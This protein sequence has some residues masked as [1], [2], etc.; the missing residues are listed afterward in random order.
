MCG[1][2]GIYNYK[3][4]SL[5]ESYVNSCLDTMKHRGP[6]AQKTWTNN[7]NY[8][9]GFTR[10]AIRDLSKNGN[11]PMLSHD[12]NYCISFNGEIYNTDTLKNAL[13]PYCISYRSTSD[14]ELLLY[15]LIHVGIEKTLDVIDGIFAFAFYDVRQNKLI[16]ARDRVGTK[17]LYIGESNDGIIYS[18]QYDHIINHP[19]C[20]DQAFDETVIASY[21]SL[22]YMPENAGVIEGTRMLPHG[23]YAMIEKNTIQLKQYYFYSIQSKE[24]SCSLDN[25]LKKSV[26]DQLV[27]DVPVGTFMSGGVDST[28][29]TYFANQLVH[30]FSFTIGVADNKDMDESLEAA[31]FAKHFGTTHFNKHISS[32]DLLPLM[33]E[34]GEAFTEPFADYSSLPSLMLS[35]FAKEKVTVSLSGDGGDELF[36]GYP[37]NARA[38][39]Y[40]HYYQ[41]SGFKKKIHLLKDK[42][43]NKNVDIAR[44]WNYTSF[45]QFYYSTF[46]ITGARKWL[47]KVYNTLPANAFF[48]NEAE[49]LYN[50]SSPDLAYEMNLMRKLEV[51]IHLQRILLKVDRASMYNS[52]EVRVPMLSNSML[53]SSLSCTYSDCIKNGLGK[54]NLRQILINRASEELA[55]QSKKGFTIPMDDWIRNEI[56]KEVTE[57]ILD[58]PATL[59]YQFNKKAVQQLL[60]QHM[61]GKENAGWFIWAIYSLVVWENLHRNKF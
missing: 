20:K 35:K 43:L 27:S 8:I 41:Y 24:T 40:L 4:R 25:V 19:F 52:L 15:T 57:K 26:N 58:M 33:K 36:W 55:L 59:S 7:T 42:V 21:L 46:S 17:P 14:T 22:G 53:K 23:F 6:D 37:R 32:A 51:D 12:N 11:Q 49:S 54:M 47:N 28:L 56:K 31:S 39:K 13:K 5:D 61:T 10:L 50:I 44:H 60:H 18:S 2:I 34:N 3:K 29:V 48:Y 16:L 30:P 1:I 45:I 38:L 9:A